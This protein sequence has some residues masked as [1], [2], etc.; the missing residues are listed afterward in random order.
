MISRYELIM[1]EGSTVLIEIR[2]GSRVGILRR[3]VISED[4]I[5]DAIDDILHEGSSNHDLRI[6]YIDVDV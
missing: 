3:I 6:V 4:E 5:E 2:R 1:R